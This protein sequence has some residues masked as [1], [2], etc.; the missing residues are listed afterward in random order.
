ML[1]GTALL[2]AIKQTADVKGSA[3]AGPGFLRF[4]DSSEQ[5]DN[6]GRNPLTSIRRNGCMSIDFT[7]EVTAWLGG[8]QGNERPTKAEY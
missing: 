8:R 6:D 1:T 5:T 4:G 2:K 7:E 3:S